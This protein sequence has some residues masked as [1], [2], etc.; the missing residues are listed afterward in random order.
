MEGTT[1]TYSASAT[2]PDNDPLSWA[3][4]YT[5]YGGSDITDV[6]VGHFN[7][8]G[9]V[10]V[11]TSVN[12]GVDMTGKDDK[13]IAFFI[14]SS[15]T[16]NSARGNNRIG[17]GAAVSGTK[18]G[19]IWT[20]SQNGLG[21]AVCYQQFETDRCGLYSQGTTAIKEI[22]F[23]EWDSLGFNVT[24]KA[25]LGGIDYSYLVING[26]QWEVGTATSKT[27]TTG[28]VDTTTGFNPTG[29]VLLG[30]QRTSVGG[31]T[32]ANICVSLGFADDAGTPNNASSQH[33]E[34]DG[35]A[36][37]RVSNGNSVTKCI[38]IADQGGGGAATVQ[39]EADLDSFGTL[40]FTLDWTTVH[41]SNG[42]Q[43]IWVVCG[44]A[45]AVAG[46]KTF[47]VLVNQSAII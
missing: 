14:N 26:G 8:A 20:T 23:K 36:S 12:I 7:A 5:I 40:K 42:Y 13:A 19:A 6:V 37:S 24:N 27:S 29:L 3:W 10:D 39:A 34:S 22:T 25:H 9:G 31:P 18:E 30:T 2:D 17:F 33:V 32:Q 4:L 35:D 41:A 15:G 47:Q 43:Y 46:R 28:T 45:A 21:N 11:D 38:V 44:D 1:V 16:V